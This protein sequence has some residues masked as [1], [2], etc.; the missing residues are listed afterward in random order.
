MKVETDDES[1]PKLCPETSLE[2]DVSPIEPKIE[3]NEQSA[4]PP[5][6]R[7]LIKTANG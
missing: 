3:I 5:L 6:K 4:P 2:Y 1:M 7:T